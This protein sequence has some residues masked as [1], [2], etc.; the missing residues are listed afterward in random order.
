M[1]LVGLPQFETFSVEYPNGSLYQ[2]ACQASE[3]LI[4]IGKIFCDKIGTGKFDI[5]RKMPEFYDITGFVWYFMI[6]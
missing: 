5:L 1:A 4:G 3:L 6:K 2:M